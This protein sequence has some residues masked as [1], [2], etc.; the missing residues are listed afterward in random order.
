M[1]TYRK[2][3]YIKGYGFLD[4][5]RNVVTNIPYKKLGTA[6]L[7]GVKKAGVNLANAASERIGHNLGSKIGDKIVT[8]RTDPAAIQEVRAQTLKDLELTPHTTQSRNK[9]LQEL[10]IV[11][12]EPTVV[13]LGALYGTGRKV[14]GGMIKYL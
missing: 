11:D 9:I 4:V 6:L 7:P 1:R 13:P 8:P 2:R 3:L 10:K 14:K 12:N 5:I